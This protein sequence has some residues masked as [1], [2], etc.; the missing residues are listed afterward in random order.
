MKFFT[1][2]II[3]GVIGAPFVSAQDCLA[4]CS[5]TTFGTPWDFAYVRSNACNNRAPL[6]TLYDNDQVYNLGMNRFGCGYWYTKV[7]V[8]SINNVG[9]VASQF[10][11]CGGNPPVPAA[12]LA[13][14]DT[15]SSS[16]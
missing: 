5:I 16:S 4:S 14:D 10:L 11:D 8:P 15:S 3:A 9:W 2:C 1:T 13:S 12:A 7:W 6:G